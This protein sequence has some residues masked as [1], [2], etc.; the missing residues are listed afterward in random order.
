MKVIL[1]FPEENFIKDILKEFDDN[2][3][4]DLNIKLLELFEIFNDF[5]NCNEVKIKVAALNKIYS[6]GILNIDPVIEKILS[7]IHF[8]T[9]NFK[10]YEFVELV[11]KIAKI[12]WIDK[13]GKNQNRKNLSFSSKYIHFLSGFKTP[14]LDSYILEL[15]KEYQKTNGK[16]ISF[17]NS[18]GYLEFYQIFEEF[19]KDFNLQRYSNYE[20]DKFLWQYA[21]NLK[22]KK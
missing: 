22:T 14:I 9:K 5:S 7:E 4:N 6:T 18:K 10:E 12:S 2:G 19:K 20:I 15:I 13:K 11:D 17:S 1:E 8:E 3:N 21:K 16:K